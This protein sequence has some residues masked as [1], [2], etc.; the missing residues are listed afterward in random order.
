VYGPGQLAVPAT[1]VSIYELTS[2]APLCQQ[3]LGGTYPGGVELRAIG[4][5]DQDGIVRVILPR[6]PRPR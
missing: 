2:E 6:A 3:A 5:S 1:L 4:V